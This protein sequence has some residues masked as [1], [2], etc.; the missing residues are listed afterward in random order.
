MPVAPAASIPRAFSPGRL[1]SAGEGSR[2]PRNAR[3]A[4]TPQA[5][6]RRK[7]IALAKICDEV[8][9]ETAWPPEEPAHHPVR[10]PFG[11]ARRFY[12]LS[13][14]SIRRNSFRQWLSG[15]VR[16]PEFGAAPRLHTRASVASRSLA[17]EA[18]AT[19]ASAPTIRAV[20]GVSCMLNRIIFVRGASRLISAAAAKPFII[21]ML[22]SSIT[23]SGVN[24]ATICRASTPL[25]A[26]PQISHCGLPASRMR[27]PIRTTSWSSAINTRA[28]IRTFQSCLAGQPDEPAWLAG[29]HPPIGYLP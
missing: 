7:G 25:E 3:G 18:L 26:S 22:R 15:A 28:E 6:C 5:A 4:E 29:T 17:A 8:S 12:V 27:T 19:N 9:A 21:G 16:G 14:F 13:F 20:A 24:S 23:M 11:S 10:E 1:E 2:A